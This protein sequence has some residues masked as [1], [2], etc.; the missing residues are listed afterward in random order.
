M[1]ADGSGAPLTI[2]IDLGTQSVRVV[3]MA[4]DGTVAGSGGAPLT[5]V[6][7][8]D[9]RHEQDPEVWW[10][11]VGEAARKV[12]GG[13]ADREIDG[14]AI[15]STSG[16]ILL[17]DAHGSPL[18]PALMY[19]DGRASEETR[20]AQEAGRSEEHT[21]ELQSPDHLVCRLLL[22]KKK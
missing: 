20:L 15:C 13:R 7:A 16:T 17:T 3:L 21:S 18:T 6:R 11:T 19:N 5:S 22:E 2:G 10:D 9:I 4:E 14:L 1:R 8:D 12:M